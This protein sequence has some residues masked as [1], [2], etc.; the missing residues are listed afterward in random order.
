MLIGYCIDP[1]NP[2]DLADL[3]PNHSDYPALVFEE[4]RYSP[5]EVTTLFARLTYPKPLRPMVN[6][7]LIRHS[8]TDDVLCIRVN[9]VNGRYSSDYRY[10]WVSLKK[11]SK[12]ATVRN[13]LYY[14]R[15][16]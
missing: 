4:P 15:D 8:S 16:M 1:E 11:L 13:V 7:F 3:W 2:I 10:K 6:A 14:E 9:D 5:V 12:E